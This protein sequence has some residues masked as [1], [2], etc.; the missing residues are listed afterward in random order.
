MQVP[1]WLS[2]Q[3]LVIGSYLTKHYLGNYQGLFDNDAIFSLPTWNAIEWL[4]EDY[5]LSQ[6]EE[7][8]WDLVYKKVMDVNWTEVAPEA[9]RKNAHFRNCKR[10]FNW[11]SNNLIDS[12]EYN[13]P[14]IPSQFD[15]ALNYASAYEDFWQKHHH[16]TA[17]FV[18]EQQFSPSFWLGFVEILR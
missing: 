16:H 4:L 7:R 15:T 9:V 14:L 13:W 11:A 8:S 5:R 3:T 10:R 1:S 18:S 2:I 6:M 17:L 12:V